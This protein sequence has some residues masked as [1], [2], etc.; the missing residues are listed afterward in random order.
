MSSNYIRQALQG[1][2][3][4]I[5]QVIIFRNIALFDVAFCFVYI[6]ILLFLPVETDRIIALI[7]AFILG[8]LIDVF[9]NS[10]GIHASSAVFLAFI[11]Y[12]WIKAIMPQ[13]GYEGNISLNISNM[14]F[15]WFTSY[16]VPIIF[17]HHLMLFFLEAGGVTHFGYTFL[18]IILSSFFTFFVIALVQMLFF[19]N[20]KTT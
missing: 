5:L 10:L 8:L 7:I 9:Y 13:G 20:K 4:I 14:G 15:Q 2:V 12:F 18:K 17:V 1:L 16:A 19:S 6:G 3:L 11:R